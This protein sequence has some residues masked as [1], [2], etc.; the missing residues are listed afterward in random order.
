MQYGLSIAFCDPNEYIP[1]AKAAEERG[2]AWVSLSDHL[3]YPQTMSA[4]YPYTAD[5]KARF[6][7]NDF[8]PEPWTA[9]TAMAQH[10]TTLRFYT[11]IYILPARNAIHA[12]KALAATSVF[13]NGRI[14]LGV[15]MGW[16]PE[17][18]SASGQ[19]FKQRGRHADEMLIVMKKLWSGEWA[20]HHGEFYD[21]GPVRM[22]PKPVTPIPI[23]IGGISDAAIKRAAKHDGWISDLHTIADLKTLIDKIYA[24]REEYSLPREGYKIS[25]FNPLD[26]H[27]REQY[28]QLETMGVTT[29]SSMPWATLAFNDNIT[30]S[31]KIK[32]MDDY[33]TA[34]I[35]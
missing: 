14:A 30:L 24:L 33:A 4:P 9:I 21:F 6:S 7:E 10:T 13:S 11:N 15:G 17:E 29:V 23:Y 5:G 26:A 19:P 2:F 3:F 27:T 32:A 20:E 16:M 25:C 31:D 34:F 35:V 12:A 28:A 18:F 22:L 1:L 8:F